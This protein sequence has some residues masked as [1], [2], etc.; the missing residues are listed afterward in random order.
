M[1]YRNLLSSI[2]EIWEKSFRPVGPAMG[3]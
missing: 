1:K 2:V 3:P